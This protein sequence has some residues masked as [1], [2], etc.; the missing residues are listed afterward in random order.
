MRRFQ[1]STLYKLCSVPPFHSPRKSCQALI[2]PSSGTA[3]PGLREQ[4]IS[5]TYPR[6]TAQTRWHETNDQGKISKPSYHTRGSHEGTGSYFGR[7]NYISLETVK[8]RNQIFASIYT[9]CL[10]NSAAITPKCRLLTLIFAC[11]PLR[12]HYLRLYYDFI[13]F[14]FQV[15]LVAF[16][17]LEESSWFHWVITI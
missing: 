6:R 10:E 11:L 9:L 8:Y 3:P 5:V 14:Y 7:N 15:S 1:S 17:G 16:A 4:L 2:V 12:S 13:Y